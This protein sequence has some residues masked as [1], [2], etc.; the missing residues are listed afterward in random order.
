MERDIVEWNYHLGRQI[1]KFILKRAIQGYMGL[2]L[3]I[4]II[5]VLLYGLLIE[6]SLR[7]M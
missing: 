6:L 4:G 5:G 3:V 7:G 1:E 2:I